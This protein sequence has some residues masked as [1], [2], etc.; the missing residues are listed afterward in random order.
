MSHVTHMNEPWHTALIRMSRGTRVNES[1]HTHEQVMAHMWMRHDTHYEWGTQHIWKSHITH[2]WAYLGL[3]LRY[4]ES[5]MQPGAVCMWYAYVCVCACVCMCYE[6]YLWN[7][8]GQSPS[9]CR[10]IHI[11]ISPYVTWLICVCDMT[12]SYVWQE[13]GVE[14]PALW[15]HRATFICVT[16]LIHTC[17]W[18]IHMF[19]TR[20]VSYHQLLIFVGTRWYVW[21]DSFTCVTWHIHTCRMS[22]LPCLQLFE[23]IEPHSYVWHDSFTRVTWLIHMFNRTHSYVW[24]SHIEH[25]NEPHVFKRVRCHITSFSNSSG[26]IHMCDRTHSY[27]GTWPIY[28]RLD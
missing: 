17:T 6:A 23:S 12:H 24:L 8:C 18:L 26:Q 21:H 10:A 5:A 25:V 9:I 14:L 3:P 1:Y 20:K 28:I 15:I 22:A 19:E 2:E 7:L 13:W 16:W 27:C 11:W 4:K